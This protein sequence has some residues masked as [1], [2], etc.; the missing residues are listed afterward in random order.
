MWGLLLAP[1]GFRPREAPGGSNKNL[2]SIGRSAAFSLTI[3]EDCKEASDNSIINLSKHNRVWD[4]LSARSFLCNYPQTIPRTQVFPFAKK[5]TRLDTD[6]LSGFRASEWQDL[7]LRPLGP[8]PSAHTKLSYIPKCLGDRSWTCGLLNP[9][10]ALYQTELHPDSLASV[11]YYTMLFMPSQ[12]F[13]EKKTHILHKTTKSL[14]VWYEQAL[15]IKASPF[16]GRMKRPEKS[17]LM[18]KPIPWNTSKIP[19]SVVTAMMPA[20]G[21]IKDIKPTTVIR[22]PIAVIQPQPRQ[23]R[24]DFLLRKSQYPQY[25]ITGRSRL[26]R[27]KSYWVRYP[28][29]IDK[30]SLL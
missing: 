25:P 17:A 21:F 1:A 3:W 10:Q 26:E 29:S 18:I 14:L 12:Y 5:Q 8:E 4:P 2:P 28:D 23:I 9:I 6:Y 13:Y 7:N 19:H 20:T 16:H 24:N 15:Y 27:L 11:I 30:Y 22:M